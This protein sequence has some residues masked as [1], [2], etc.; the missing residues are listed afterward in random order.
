MSN[1]IWCLAFIVCLTLGD[2]IWA[3]Q[4][5]TT[6]SEIPSQDL[7]EVTVTAKNIERT[8]ECLR[9]RPTKQQRQLSLSADNLVDNLM[10]PGVNVDDNGAISAMGTSATLYVNG[11]ES[12]PEDIKRIRPQDVDHIEYYEHPTTR[13]PLAKKAFNFVLKKHD[14]G[15]YVLAMASQNVG[16]RRGNGRVAA[17]FNKGVN[18]FSL[19]GSGLYS[20][21]EGTHT[22][23]T[24]IYHLPQGDVKRESSSWSGSKGGNQNAQFRWQNQ[25][26][27]HTIITMASLVWRQMPRSYS[28]DLLTEGENQHSAEKVA[29]SHSLA[30][31]LKI[32]GDFKLPYNQQLF[33]D[34]SG[35]YVRTHFNRLYEEPDFYNYMR[36]EENAYNC[37][38]YLKWKRSEAWGT[39]SA[40]LIYTLN[41][42]DISDIGSIPSSMDLRQHNATII[43]GYMRNWGSWWLN[44]NAGGEWTRNINHNVEAYTLW[45]PRGNIS[46]GKSTKEQSFSFFTTWNA[47][48]YSPVFLSTSSMWINPYLEATGN[49][50]LK[51]AHQIGFGGEYSRELG[52]V[53][54]SVGANGEFDLH[55][56]AFRFSITDNHILRTYD[57]FNF[58]KPRISIYATY[59]PSPRI[60]IAASGIASQVY[61]NGQSFSTVTTYNGSLSAKYMINNFMLNASLR[62]QSKYRDPISGQLARGPLSYDIGITYGKDNLYI[63]MQAISP[64]SPSHYHIDFTS[65]YWDCHQTQTIKGRSRYAK[66]TV[67]YSIDFGRRVNRVREEQPVAPGSAIITN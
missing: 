35:S 34:L 19:F 31:S 15:G 58:F 66:I 1:R 50:A 36:Q 38:G 64:F 22:S 12:T 40:S 53:S 10:L 45:N 44:T 47:S 8:A 39:I 6:R 37:N 54:F 11:V 5:D 7:K 48:T 56:A 59:K 18:T 30:P 32:T 25:T 14:S 33:I 42:W 49:P 52:R 16:Y 27:S 4:P 43:L 20:N 29:G 13:F 23:S 67:Q 26:N 60:V 24:D 17:T 65:S 2:D 9:I 57:S 51:K 41:R 61:F 63:A 21:I 55:E 3:L 62:G 28:D 46:A